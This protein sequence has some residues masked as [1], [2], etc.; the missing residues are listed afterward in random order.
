MKKIVTLFVK[1]PFYANMVIA[2][3]V[4]AGLLGFLGMKN[5]FLP[6]RPSRDI[7]VTITYPGASPKEMEEALAARVEEAVRGIVGIEE[8]NSTS[9]ENSATVRITTTGEY[10][11]DQTLSEVKNAVDSISSFP[12]DAEK[13]I[14]F[15]QRGTTQGMYMGL[16]GDADLMTLKKR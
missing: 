4:V 5:S 13:P 6:E 3:I 8:I 16:S 9:R 15:K 11:L 14:V 12:V 7:F 1:Y 10:D 2:I